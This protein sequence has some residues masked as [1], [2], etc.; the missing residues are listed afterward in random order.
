MQRASQSVPAYAPFFALALALLLASLPKLAH[1]QDISGFVSDD[2]SATQLDRNNWNF[3]DPRGDSTASVNGTQLLIS[4]PAGKNHDMRTTGNFSARVMQSI[5][6]TDFQLEAKFIS[7]VQANQL[8]GITIEQSAGTFLRFDFLNNGTQ[9]RVRSTV[10]VNNVSSSKW[11]RVIAGAA[12]MYLRVKREG[13]I[14]NYHFSY[15]GVI[16]NSA[17]VMTN[18]M[19]PNLAGVFAGNSG[20]ASAPAHTA[21]IDYMFSTATPVT[22]E[23]G[24][25][26]P[27]STAPYI[28][29]IKKLNGANQFQVLWA[30]DEPATS[31]ME[32]GPTTSYGAS[33]NSSILTR[34]HHQLATGLATNQTY[35]FRL[36]SKDAAGNETVSEDFTIKLS[37][38]P[39]LDLW[40]GSIQNFGQLGSNAQRWIN[41]P[42]HVSGANPI[43]SLAYSLNGAPAQSL[44]LGAD[45]LRLQD[46]NDFNADIEY[47]DFLSGANTLAITAT[48]SAGN[49]QTENLAIAYA[50]GNTWPLPYSINWSSA[51][52]IANVAQIV[53]G[54]WQITGNGVRTRQVGY[55]RLINIGDISWDD[56]EVTLP[57][58]LHGVDQNCLVNLDTGPCNEGPMVGVLVR[59][60]GHH[61]DNDQPNVEWRPLGALAAYRWKNNQSSQ[62]TE[63]GLFMLGGDGSILAKDLEKAFAVGTT[64]MFK[65]R[66]ETVDGQHEYKTKMWPQGQAEPVQWDITQTQTIGESNSNGSLL[67][68][69]HYADATFG[70]IT[71]TSLGGAGGG[72]TTAP[73]ISNVKATV[74]AT[75]ATITWN[76]NEAAS[77]AVAYGLTSAYGTNASNA[78]PVTSHSVTLANL[79]IG[80]QYQYRV[81]ST[82]GAN[83]IGSGPGLTFVTASGNTSTSGI[84]ADAFDGSS[85][86]MS[87][88]TWVDPVGDSSYSSTGSQV[89]LA[90][91]AGTQHD[92]W[93]NANEAPRILQSASNTDLQLEVKFD[94]TLT[95]AYQMQGIVVQGTDN[96]L[97]RFDFYSD[98]S[99][100]FIHAAT[101]VNNKA[102]KK[103]RTSIVDGVPLYLRVVRKGNQWS[104]YYSYDGANWTNAGTFAHTLVVTAAGV[105]GGNAGP[106]PAHNA[107][108]D[109]FTVD[110]LPPGSGSVSDTTPPLISNVQAAV[111]ETTATITW[112]TNEAANST[113][114]YGLTT[115]YGLNASNPA[116]LTMHS[117]TLNNLAPNTQYHF[118]VGS[119]DASGNAVT[120]TDAIFSTLS[121]NAGG[122]LTAVPIS[123]SRVDLY[124]DAL[125]G[126][127][128]YRIYRDAKLLGTTNGAQYSDTSLVANKTYSYDVVALLSTGNQS[129]APPSVVTT[130][131]SNKGAWWNANWPYR[132]LIGI[133]TGQFPRTNRVAEL[134]LNITEVLANIGGSGTFNPATV[135]CREVDINGAILGN[136][137]PCQ[138]EP[139]ENF[140]A[141]NLATGKLVI[142]APGVTA[143][144]SARYFHLYFDTVGG[145]STTSTL[146]PLVTVVDNV[147]D[148]GQSSFKIS[149]STGSYF[150]QKEAGAFSSM[151][152]TQGNDWIDYHPT[153]NAAG[154]YR[155]IP[156]LVYP[157]G[158]FHPGS[159]SALSTIVNQGPLKVTVRSTTTDGLWQLTWEFYPNT[160]TMTMLAAAKTYWFLYEGT[161]GGKLETATDFMVRSNGVSNL[162]SQPWDG[163]IA[164]D[165]WVYF[166]DPTVGKS[167]FLAHHE[168]DSAFDSYRPM[169]GQMTVFGFGRKQTGL[170]SYMNQTPAHFT[171][172]LIEQTSYAA[173]AELINSAIKPL[174]IENSGAATSSD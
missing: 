91:P 50:S 47:V 19:V 95:S 156:N 120:G 136:E 102:T 27:D 166:A 135:R 15:D 97:L 147:N 32:Y 20:N 8:Q 82:D 83:N 164:G 84:V 104:E 67:L 23:D 157:E 3:I 170:N 40:Y 22:P 112:Q 21:I 42:G 168:G 2:F 100:M 138:F 66:A 37:A 70:N 60:Q 18:T 29:N 28:R 143:A 69:A 72:D 160:A 92:L 128:G 54:A 119:T 30:T 81:S 57:I 64:R 117:V 129:I 171:I 41:I 141:T 154:N 140:D 116:M 152:D 132:T 12:P 39:F 46:D 9:T 111:A 108:I 167:L 11:E 144:R 5:Y 77:S 105:F 6:N 85:L 96:N 174:D 45:G 125:A 146:T 107:L 76:T 53:D 4:V 131:A 103:I 38:K 161:P 17:R 149:T 153:G 124:W 34:D 145:S 55:D 151:L 139:S 10:Y 98:G 118:R 33:V 48:D 94:S 13:N 88:W 169:N 93:A 148:E 155:G 71:V 114:N 173:A 133:G 36:R 90:V 61:V 142:L 159:T 78:T 16:W 26:I 80:T 158:H 110:G 150:F 122:T 106:S 165:E 56:Y 65:V 62:Q 87:V 113:V 137:I 73:V 109:Y 51:A 86:N 1:A 163:D 52:S 24:E 25:I 58:T 130:I 134:D 7:P 79:S 31:R 89:S 121:S 63:P 35:H 172:G 99:S 126:A 115:A 162:L 43:S 123:S 68:V 44:S 101:L 59:W 75:T 49:Q 127:T 74:T 14:W